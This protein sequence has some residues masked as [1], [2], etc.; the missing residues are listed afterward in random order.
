MYEYQEDG[1]AFLR[2]RGRA[3]LGDEAGLGK[4]RQLLMAAEGRTLVIA[5]AMILDSGTWDA[6]VARWRPDLDVTTVPYTSLCDRVK[7][8][9]GSG[10][11]PLPVPRAEYR[12]HWDTVILD[13]SHYIKGRKTTWTTAVEKVTKEADRVYLATGTPIPN[14]AHELFVP[15]KLV[16]PSDAKPKRKYGSYWRWVKEWFAVEPNAWNP[17]SL[18]IGDLRP[19]RTWDEFHHNNLGDR[20]LQRLRDQVL[21]DLPPLTGP[22]PWKVR[23]TPSQRR[24]YTALKKNFI[25]DTDNGSIVAWSKSG[26]AVKLAKVATGLEI[27][28]PGL[29]GSGKLDALRD[30][31]RDRAQ[32]TFVVAHFRETVRACV[33]V[34][35]ELG[36]RTV[37]V[38]GGTRPAHR[39][40]AVQDFQDGLADV[41][42]GT[43]E[44]VAEGITL[45]RADCVI[46]VERSWRPSKNEQ[47]IRRI[48]RIGQDRPVTAIDLITERSLDG[49]QLDVLA[50]KTDQQVQALTAAQFAQ[51]L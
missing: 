15:L 4:T 5:P 32:P 1:I 30:I 2:S 36:L 48:H 33:R 10:T 35:E 28:D 26:L 18:D 49:H 19:D 29:R 34:A 37:S 21:T 27:E 41:F 39:K 46:R 11:K 12:G 24:V 20:F 16:Y 50:D 40:A 38:D 45:T 51:L 31:L 44:T 7:T 23:M 13:E 6:E 47:V 9:N 14:W 22:I 43:I 25:A 8:G 3:M 17:N 42:V